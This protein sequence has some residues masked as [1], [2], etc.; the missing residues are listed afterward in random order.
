MNERYRERLRMITEHVAARGVTDVFVLEALRRVP[1]HAFTLPEHRDFAYCDR[2]LPIGHGQTISQPYVAA[3]MTQELEIGPT[4]RVLEIGTGSG[5]QTAVLAEITSSVYSVELVQPLAQRARALLRELGYNHVRTRC[6][7]GARGWSEQAPFDAIIVTAA[8]QRIPRRLFEQL[9]PGGRMC[10][11]LGPKS[12]NQA[13]TIV[14]KT[15]NGAMQTREVSTVRF[16]PLTR[17]TQQ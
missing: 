1:R 2:P 13:L 12:G 10:I 5:Y 4:S 8:P 3:R 16:V 11:P 6:A 7:D 14:E 15:L 9:A 17:E